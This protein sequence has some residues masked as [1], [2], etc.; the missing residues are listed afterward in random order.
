MA[1]RPHLAKFGNSMD[2]VYLGFM[3]R[4]AAF[5][6]EDYRKAQ[7]ARSRL[8]R[9]FQEALRPL[10]RDRHPDFHPHRPSASPLPFL[11]GDFSAMPCRISCHCHKTPRFARR[12]HI[13]VTA[14]ICYG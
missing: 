1:G 2:P 4:G 7:L 3:E 13:G 12:P 14:R 6:I 11:T 10:R 8:Y 9:R 5:T